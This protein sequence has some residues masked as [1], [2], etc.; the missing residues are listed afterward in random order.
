[1]SGIQP[2]EGLG[3]VPAEVELILS[4]TGADLAPVETVEGPVVE[5]QPEEQA[6]GA[7]HYCPEYHSLVLAEHMLADPESAHLWPGE[8]YVQAQRQRVGRA[9]AAF[10][11]ASTNCA[12]LNSDNSCPMSVAAWGA[13]E[14]TSQMPAVIHDIPAAKPKNPIGFRMP[15]QN[16]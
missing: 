4:R 7:E 5:E 10:K 3:G 12:G 1:M 8:G 16:A 2:V 15:D 9:C 11:L 13:V 6:V 14:I